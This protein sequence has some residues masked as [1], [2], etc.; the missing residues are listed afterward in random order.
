MLSASS[1]SQQISALLAEVQ[2]LEQRLKSVQQMAT[3]QS[4]ETNRTHDEAAHILSGVESVRLPNVLSGELAGEVASVKEGGADALSK[5]RD[6]VAEQAD[7][8]AETEKLL[9]EAREQL[10]AAQNKQKVQSIAEIKQYR[11]KHNSASGPIL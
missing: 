1:T 9:T 3:E 5:T 2:E 7:A 4:L 6:A 8:L 10:A 11:V